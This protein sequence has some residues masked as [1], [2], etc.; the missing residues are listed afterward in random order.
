[1]AKRHSW[2]DIKARTT[3][4]ARARIE[5]DARRLSEG[6][7]G[8]AEQGASDRNPQDDGDVSRVLW[9]KKNGVT[10]C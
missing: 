9:K 4:E 2:S 8:D 6:I 10:S 7:R 5:S 3:P 1:M